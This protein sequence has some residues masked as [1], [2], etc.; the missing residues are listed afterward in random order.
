[1]NF[2]TEVYTRDGDANLDKLVNV[3]DV[4][5][6]VSYILKD[7][8]NMIDRFGYYEADVNYDNYVEV[9]DVIEVGPISFHEASFQRRLGPSEPVTTLLLPKPRKPNVATQNAPRPHEAD[10]WLDLS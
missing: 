1:M 7:Q 10:T 8:E 9:A 3:A 6:T 4:T 5:A 2:Q